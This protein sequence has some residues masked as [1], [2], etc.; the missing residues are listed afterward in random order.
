MSTLT[1]RERNLVSLGAA[2]ASNCVPCVEYH[3]PGAKK[4]G[5]SDSQINE[6]LQIAVLKYDY[7]SGF[8]GLEDKPENYSLVTYTLE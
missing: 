1:D 2:V 8:S 3:V 7:W 4:V 6:A 5:L